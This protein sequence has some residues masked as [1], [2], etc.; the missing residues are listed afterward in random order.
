M[1]LDDIRYAQRF[2]EHKISFMV[3]RNVCHNE[4]AASVIRYPRG[5]AVVAAPPLERVP[6]FFL[7]SFAYTLAFDF[8][9]EWYFLYCSSG[10]VRWWCLFL[11][12]KFISLKRWPERVT[13]GSSM[14]SCR[15]LEVPEQQSPELEGDCLKRWVGYGLTQ[16]PN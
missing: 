8:V 7:V 4:T 9:R 16:A 15:I 12:F 2:L 1:I 10:R 11:Y 5:F 6:Q 14:F 3:F 13:F